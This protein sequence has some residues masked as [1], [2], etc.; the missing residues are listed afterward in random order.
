[1]NPKTSRLRTI[2]AGVLCL[3]V[4][5]ASAQAAP[6]TETSK[7]AASPAAVHAK[8]A[9]VAYNLADWKTAIAEYRAAYAADQKAAYLF[10]LAQSQRMSGDCAGAIDSY[11]AFK[12]AAVS[13]NQATAAEL[14]ITKCQAQIEQQKANAAM[15]RAKAEKS[16]A[17][18]QPASGATAQPATATKS[19]TPPPAPEKP[20]P[21][22]EDAFGHVLFIAGAGATVAGAVFLAS[23][24]SDV[25][26]KNGSY[27]AVKAQHDSGKKKQVLGVG[28]LVVGGALIAGAILRYALVGN[29]EP[30]KPEHDKQ[31]SIYGFAG[32]HR[33]E[34]GVTGRF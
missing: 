2:A 24:N 13:A 12:R 6:P 26:S 34:L 14:L 3:L 22:Y 9:G 29:G 31:A 21:W 33:A 1:M 27:S 23:G 15:A 20:T 8:K 25:N 11:K 30:S 18:K 16:T 10:G 7:H 17:A 32:P 28:G 19:K 4:F 5:A